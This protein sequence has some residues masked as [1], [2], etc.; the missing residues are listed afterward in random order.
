MT[1]TCV[2]EAEGTLQMAPSPSIEGAIRPGRSSSRNVRPSLS[3][4]AT[5]PSCDRTAARL[6]SASSSTD[7]G[8]KD[9]TASDRPLIGSTASP[10]SEPN[11]PSAVSTAGAGSTRVTR[12]GTSDAVTGVP[13][14][15]IC[16]SLIPAVERLRTSWVCMR[17]RVVRSRLSAACG[18]CTCATPPDD[19]VTERPTSDSS[20]GNAD[21]TAPA[22]Q[23]LG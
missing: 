4:L 16:T 2:G 20:S 18:N 19:S 13:S 3:A 12:T 23:G 10:E 21:L 14:T 17:S 15:V 7:A 1:R 5:S 8:S 6:R 11:T 22:S 9:S